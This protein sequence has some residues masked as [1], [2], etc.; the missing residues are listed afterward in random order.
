MMN[1]FTCAMLLLKK[2]SQRVTLR[3]RSGSLWV[4]RDVQSARAGT[5]LRVLGRGAGTPEARQIPCTGSAAVSSSF[6]FP[7]FSELQFFNRCR[8]STF[9]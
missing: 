3:L 7:P 8:L 2:G 9:L 1:H 5:R 6:R 4:P